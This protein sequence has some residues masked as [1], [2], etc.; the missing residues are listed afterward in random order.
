MMA[1]RAEEKAAA[2]AIEVREVRKIE[3]DRQV[4]LIRYSPDGNVLFGGGYDSQIRRWDLT[5]DEPVLMEPL[6]GHH[7]WVQSMAFLPDGETLVSVDSW[8]QLCAWSVHDSVPDLKWHVER[9]H[10]GWLH[11]LA[12]SRDGSVLAT[13]GRDRYVRLWSAGD[14]ALIRQLHRH[15]HEPFCV[16]IHPDNQS[17]VSADLFGTLRHWSVDSAET[18]RELSLEKMHYYERIQDVRGVFVLQFDDTGEALICAGGQPTNTG[19][20]QGIPTIHQID[21]ESFTA[22]RSHSFGVTTDGFVFDLIRHPA[23]YFFA[24]TSGNPG[25]GQLLLIDPTHDEPLFK[26]TKMSNCHSVTLHPDGKTLVVSATNRNSQGNGAVR[27]KEG[28]YLGNSSPLH[29]FEILQPAESR[30]G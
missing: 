24:V 14:G 3:T 21:W 9:A 7:G 20:H 8:G 28:K 10:D 30:S 27:D 16:A 26:Y 19:N 15:E 5:A 22:S 2:P 11:D 6:T 1:P 25:A 17:V 4:C 12:V 13:V 23:G 29:V 18:V